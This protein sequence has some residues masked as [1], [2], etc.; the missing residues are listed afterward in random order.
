MKSYAAK[1]SRGG[2]PRAARFC[3]KRRCRPSAARAKRAYSTSVAP[4]SWSSTTLRCIA[5]VTCEASL[6]TLAFRQIEGDTN[7]VCSRVEELSLA[8]NSFDAVVAGDMLQSVPDDVIALR[9][10]R[11]VL[12]DGGLLCLT[13]P[14]YPFLWGEDDELRGHQR[15]YTISELRRKLNTCGFH[16]HRASYFVASAFPPLVAGRVAKDIFHKSIDAAPALSAGLAGW[17]MRP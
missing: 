16:I 13:V 7:L 9:E 6:K 11:R 10:M 5:F 15:R 1:A 3:A 2:T 4:H 14:A 12:K 17:R 8:S